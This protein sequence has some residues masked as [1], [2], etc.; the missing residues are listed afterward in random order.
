MFTKLR[1]SNLLRPQQHQYL[2]YSKK[3]TSTAV[4]TTST[5][6]A[7]TTTLPPSP[8]LEI[9]PPNSKQ[10]H[11]DLASYLSTTST[12]RNDAVFLG[13][14]YEYIVQSSLYRLGFNV[15]HN[16]GSSDKGIDLIGH[17]SIPSHPS[18]TA[19][20][21]TLKVLIQCKAHE[22]RVSPSVI[23]ELA[24]IFA[25]APAS[26]RGPGGAIAFLAST[27]PAT[28]GVRDAMGRSMLPL[29][30]LC[31]DRE[32]RVTQMLWNRRGQ[33]E[34]LWGW[35]VG[36][37]YGKGDETGK[38]VVALTWMGEPVV[39]EE[40]ATET[41]SVREDGVSSTVSQQDEASMLG[42]LPIQGEV[43]A[44]TDSQQQGIWA[45]QDIWAIVDAVPVVE[46]GPI[47]HEFPVPDPMPKVP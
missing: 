21:L 10:K 20:S 31:V 1:R 12:T 4:A 45:A 22:R 33:E 14:K 47:Q 5:A 27:Q 7:T 35:G 24:G 39:A 11:H 34:G 6:V 17:W 44:T 16:G 32:G 30:F 38:G 42:D 29:G 8:P 43:P 28:K 25:G 13:T 26:H 46:K 2:K 9:L 19:T 37:K 36:V 23:R 40:A 3:S 15:A 41:G 18:P